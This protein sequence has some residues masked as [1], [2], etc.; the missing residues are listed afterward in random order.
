MSAGHRHAAYGLTIAANRPLPALGPGP[1]DAPPDLTIDFRAGEEPPVDP[2]ARDATDRHGW[3]STRELPD[4]RRAFRC[5]ASAGAR[6]WSMDITPDGRRIDVRW[7]AA[8]NLDD[9]IA[10][11]LTRGL[12]ACLVLRGVPLLHACGIVFDTRAALVIG[13]SGAGKSTTA[14]AAVAGGAAILTDDMAAL[15]LRD[16][17]VYVEPGARRLRLHEGT[18]GALGWEA[19]ALPR[20]FADEFLVAKRGVDVSVDDGTYWDRPVALGA[21]YVLGAREPAGPRLV[22]LTP[23]EALPL[24]LANTFADDLADRERRARLLP[25]WVRLAQHIP[26][27][28]VHARDGLGAEAELV[29]ALAADSSRPAS[30]FMPSSSEIRGA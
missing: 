23:Q 15:T 3:Y 24:L 1:E 7:S 21:I 26:V 12:A 18:A 25:G 19:A 14:A 11:V 6:A 4:G 2:E 5:A 16:D 17:G 9:V 28:R 13:A 8:M 27:R 22:A 29:A 10:F 20:V 30:P